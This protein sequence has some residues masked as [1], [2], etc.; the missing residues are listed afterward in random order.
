MKIQDQFYI[1]GQWTAPLDGGVLTDVIDPRT[2][3]P[4][5]QVVLGGAADVDRAALAARRAFPA[6][7]RSSREDRIALLEA[8]LA[9]FEARE[10]ELAAVIAQEIGSPA[11][12]AKGGH[13]AMAKAHIAV[14]IEVLRTYE[15]DRT[16]GT[17]L[18]HHAPIGVAGLITPWNF[19]AS[20]ITCKLVPALAT[21][22]TV[23]LLSLIHI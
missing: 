23:V 8:L 22:C 20:T 6:F 9:R 13:T 2:E 3:Q 1:D 16:M 7:A 12:L 5:G 15:F 17:T 21:G 14:A 18:I 10:D 4:F 11:W 19:P